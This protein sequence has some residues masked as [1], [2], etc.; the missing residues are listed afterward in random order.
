MLLI[1]AVTHLSSLDAQRNTD[2]LRRD[3]LD[4]RRPMLLTGRSPHTLPR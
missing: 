3:M 1:S 4:P 2:V